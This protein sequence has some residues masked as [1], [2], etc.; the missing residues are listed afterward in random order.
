M[1][2]GQVQETVL[3][4]TPIIA[5]TVPL[6]WRWPNSMRWVSRCLACCVGVALLGIAVSGL[7]HGSRR[8]AA[9]HRWLPHYLF[10][11]AWYA[12]PIAIGVTLARSRASPIVRAGRSLGLL[13]LL[14][15]IFVASVTGYLGPSHG[16]IDSMALNRFRVLHYGVCPSVAIVLVIWWYHG[17]EADRDPRSRDRDEP[18]AEV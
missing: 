9:I 13:L 11:L 10:F 5:T 14:G 12:V 2:E 18:G 17:L 7:L 4:F 8:A 15:A 3:W 16:P 6:S 1:A